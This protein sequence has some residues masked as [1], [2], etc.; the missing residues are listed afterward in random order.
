MT[1]QAQLDLFGPFEDS[2]LEATNRNS[3]SQIN[4]DPENMAK[5]SNSKDNLFPETLLIID[6]ETTGLNHETDQ[7]IEIGAVL[8]HVLSRSVLAQQS[9]LLPTINNS[10]E[11]INRIPAEITRVKQPWRE[12][13]CYFEKLVNDSDILVAHNAAFDRKWFGREPLPDLSNKTWLCS[14]DEISWPSD[15]HLRVRPSVRDLALA[16]EVPVWSAHRA[17]TDCIYLAEVFRRCA[18]L[19]LLILHGLEP[20]R[21]MRAQISY[22][23]RHLAKQAGFTWN[24]PVHGAWTKKLSE[25]EKVTLP[26]QVVPVANN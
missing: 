24:D 15:R 17:L 23:Q 5:L 11:M 16:Y 10:A 1:A 21:L 26:F 9:L 12:G 20:R 18:D 3:S 4:L 8:F 14:M 2:S 25:R 19:E 7:C 22:E 6:T 13:L